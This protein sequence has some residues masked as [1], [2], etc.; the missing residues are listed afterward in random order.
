MATHQPSVPASTLLKWWGWV[1][2][3]MFGMTTD[4]VE[5]GLLFKFC[6]LFSIYLNKTSQILLLFTFSSP[7]QIISL[8][9][10]CKDPGA[11]T[12]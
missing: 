2:V 10:L 3:D 5:K 9:L 7:E 6:L 11:F 1:F 12:L 4:I 8:Q